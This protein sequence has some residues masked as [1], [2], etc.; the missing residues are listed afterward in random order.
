MKLYR[1]F[2][3]CPKKALYICKSH[4]QTNDEGTEWKNTIENEVIV[5]PDRILSPP[6]VGSFINLEIN[7]TWLEGFFR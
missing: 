5:C 1:A 7:E 3:S 4:K 6:I 2:K